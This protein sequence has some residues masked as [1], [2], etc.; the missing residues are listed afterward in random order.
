MAKKAR[1]KVPKKDVFRII[2][3]IYFIIVML[4]SPAN[5]TNQINRRTLSNDSAKT[6]RNAFT[7]AR[8]G[9]S[10]VVPGVRGT[11]DKDYPLWPLIKYTRGHSSLGGDDFESPKLSILREMSDILLQSMPHY[12]TN[13]N[14]KN[15]DYEKLINSVE[16]S[17]FT[18]VEKSCLDIMAKSKRDMLF[19][20][21]VG[22][23]LI[24]GN[25]RLILF[26]IQ[27]LLK[28]YDEFKQNNTNI[29][30]ND[31]IKGM[32]SVPVKN[33]II[34]DFER[35]NKSTREL[36]NIFNN[37][38]QI[39]NGTRTNTP[40]KPQPQP[41]MP[42][43]PSAPAPI[44]KSVQME[45]DVEVTEGCPS[46]GNEPNSNIPYNKQVLTF[47]PDKNPNCKNKDEV[48][49]KFLDLKTIFG[50][51]GGKSKR[52]RKAKRKSKKKSN[53]KATKRRY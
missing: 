11:R 15:Y 7:S 19:D 37:L 12:L 44:K 9:L 35:Y 51:A 49:R 53:K 38:D 39:F 26:Y 20:Y 14:F 18:P 22:M 34:E 1:V 43:M 40:P 27:S 32:K 8:I 25:D 36:K 50:K 13:E 42:Q 4:D 47:H 52:T 24:Y 5:F 17:S 46:A 41:Q 33:I 23:G 28:W 16:Y 29:T 2:I 45:V 3:F 30:A 10:K 21:I 6:L 31:I 48:N